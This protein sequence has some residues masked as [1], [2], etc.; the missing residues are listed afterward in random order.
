MRIALQQPPQIELGA[1]ALLSGITERANPRVALAVGMLAFFCFMPYPA[2][3]VGNRS[4]IQIGNVLTVLMCLPMLGVSWRRKSFHIFWLLMVPLCLSMLKVALTGDGDAA[5]CLKSVASRP[6]SYLTILV[7]QFYAPMY[8]LEML[9]GI[10]LAT[11]IHFTVGIW[12]IY[13]FTNGDFPMAELYVNTSFLSVQDMVKTIANYIQRPFGIFPEPSAM[14]SSLAPWILFW[15]GHLCG[16]IRLKREPARWQRVLFGAAA[17]CGLLL[18]ILSRSGH[19]IVTLLPVVLFAAVWFTRSRATGRTYLIILLVC[20]V[21]LPLIL[22]LGAEAMGDRLGGKSDVGNSSWEERSASLWAGFM[23]L[24]NGNLATLL[25]GIGPGLCAPVVWGAARLDAVWSVL[26]NYVYETGLVGAIVVGYVGQ[27][28]LR[29][30][31][32]ERFNVVFASIGFVW[33]IGVLLTT[34][35]EQLLPIWLTL[36]WLTVW[37]AICRAPGETESVEQE[38]ASEPAASPHILDRRFL[39]ADPWGEA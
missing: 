31:K 19:T 29:I 4:A 23:M 6:I 1:P 38:V 10:A 36:G 3:T 13:C 20:C 18:I 34:S 8:A 27:Y 7:V 35:Y 12:Q 24:T 11:L 37:P 32:S 5:L 30:W 21:V 2:L 22:W 33:F 9:T 25:F 14:S 26:L 16:F 39:R 15:I 28:L 17:V